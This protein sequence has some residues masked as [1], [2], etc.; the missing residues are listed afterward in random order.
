[1]MISKLNSYIDIYALIFTW[2][3]HYQLILK[4]KLSKKELIYLL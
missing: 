4:I 1:M 2:I 3:G